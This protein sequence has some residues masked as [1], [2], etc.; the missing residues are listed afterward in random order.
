MSK[1]T[2][3]LGVSILA[4]MVAGFAAYSVY[5]IDDIKPQSVAVEVKDY[6]N[7]FESIQSAIYQVNQ[8]LETFESET[9]K[10]LEQIKTELADKVIPVE[11]KTQQISLP[12]KITTNKQLFL[13]NDVVIISIE[14]VSPQTS[15]KIELLSSSNELIVT[16][17]VFSDSAGRIQTILQL[18]ALIPAGN[19]SVQ[20]TY[21]GSVDTTLITVIEQDASNS[22]SSE[23]L[24]SQTVQSK[25]TLIL[26]KE[27]YSLGDIIFVSGVGPADSSVDLEIT[28]PNDR[29]KT[30]HSSSG[31]DGTYTIIYMI[32]LDAETGSWEINLT[33]GNEESETIVE[34]IA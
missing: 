24:T 23:L 26:D 5:Y 12:F 20:T 2:I 9:V 31:E 33:V 10:E 4:L 17:N 18:P 34:I 11:Q 29:I 1:E 19:Y 22:E 25:L 28:D 21:N 7:D 3:M 6:T 30:S 15:I 13:Q 32:P 27:Q 8:N 16:K 14:N